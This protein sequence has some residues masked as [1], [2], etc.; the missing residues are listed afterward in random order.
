MPARKPSRRHS[1]IQLPDEKAV[2]PT[3]DTLPVKPVR[4]TRK[5]DE[6]LPAPAV[7][8]RRQ[9]TGTDEPKTRTK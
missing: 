8:R 5:A 2:K 6:P 7:D 1:D 3:R 4:R 9:I